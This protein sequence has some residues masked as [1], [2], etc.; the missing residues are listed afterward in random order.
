MAMTATVRSVDEKDGSMGKAKV[1]EL[2]TNKRQA[3]ADVPSE[4]QV[5]AIIHPYKQRCS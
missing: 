4:P 1:M 5:S 2:H 3:E